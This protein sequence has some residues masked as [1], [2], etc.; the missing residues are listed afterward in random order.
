MSH[1]VFPPPRKQFFVRICIGSNRLFHA[2]SECFPIHLNLPA[3]TVRSFIRFRSG[4]SGLPI[5]IGRSQNVPRHL[6]GC[7][8][9]H[10]DGLCDEY[11]LMFECPTLGSLRLKYRDLFTLRT[12]TMQTFM[13][14]KETYL[15][16]RFVTQALAVLCNS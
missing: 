10:S 5:D 7:P 3:K 12:Q 6:R 8:T 2:F 1:L 11:H 15:V 4:C 16:A 9:C 14:Q 13:W